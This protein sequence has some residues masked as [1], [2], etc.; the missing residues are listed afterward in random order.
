MLERATELWGTAAPCSARSTAGLAGMGLV[1]LARCRSGRI[2][3]DAPYAQ[4]YSISDHATLH[5]GLSP[6]QA[7]PRPPRCGLARASP[8]RTRCARHADEAGDEEVGRVAQGQC[9]RKPLLGPL[10]T[11]TVEPHLRVARAREQV[12]H[13]RPRK[14]A[15]VR[16]VHDATVLIPP[17]LAQQHEQG[18]VVADVRQAGHDASSRS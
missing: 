4:L 9:A 16:G 8:S 13:P 5:H 17:L 6:A 7:A 18:A 15:Q 1:M 10:A 12:E 2:N 3:P 14:E 11:S